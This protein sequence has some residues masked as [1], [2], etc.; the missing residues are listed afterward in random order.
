MPNWFPPEVSECLR[1]RR[2]MNAD[3]L[4]RQL[5]DRATRGAVLSTEEQAHLERWYA[6]QD[7]EE[8]AA[9]ARS[10]PGPDAA[11]LQAQVAAALAQLLA[12]TQRIQA[13]AADN[14]AV[15]RDIAALHRELARQPKT[16]PV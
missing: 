3:D 11:A 5:H 16:Q 12:V 1:K 15:R 6:Q 13:L 9:L 14:E 7:L 2:T 8:S 4:G 10:S